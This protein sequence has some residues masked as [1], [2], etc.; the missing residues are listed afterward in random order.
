MTRPDYAELHQQGF[1][2]VAQIK[3]FSDEDPESYEAAVI[4]HNQKYWQQAME[5]ELSSQ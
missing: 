4:S 1:A 2:R 3:A 5:E